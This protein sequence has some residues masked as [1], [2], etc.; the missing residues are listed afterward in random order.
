MGLSK[1]PWYGDIVLDWL[2]W[3]GWVQYNH[4]SLKMKVGRLPLCLRGKESS[5]QCRRHRFNLR[6]RKIPG[7]VEQLSPCMLSHAWQ[8]S[9]SMEFFRQD[10]WSELPF[11][12]SGDFPDRGIK[13]ASP[14]SP[15]LTVGFFTAAPPGKPLLF[16]EILEWD[17]LSVFLM[18]NFIA[19]FYHPCEGTFQCHSISVISLL[20][21]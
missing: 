17:N 8:A 21:E 16:L 6:S 9:L 7:A 12:T 10:Y 14:M 20:W 15:I 1:G 18:L 5:C 3:I 13:P 11:P 2:D 4:V 19:L